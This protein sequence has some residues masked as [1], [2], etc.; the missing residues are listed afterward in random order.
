MKVGVLVPYTNTNLEKDLFSLT[1]PNVSFH[2]TRIGGYDLEEIPDHD[3][4]KKMGDSDLNESLNLISAI[5]P[6]IILYGCTSATLTRGLKYNYYL[7]NLIST[8]TNSK[9]VTAS[10]ALINAINDLKIK[11]IGFASPYE[12]KI[13]DN[14]ISFFSDAG[15][16]TISCSN[17][18]SKIK[19]LEQG[20]LK[21]SE[22]IELVLQA[23]SNNADAII[24][25][26]TDLKTLEIIEQLEKKLNK[27]VISSNQAMIYSLIKI[28]NIRPHNNFPGKL[29]KLFN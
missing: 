28:L 29:F 2:F 23:N 22:I 8:K 24:L 12:K 11:K 19:S 21:S 25:S 17:I 5:K 14:A 4:M 20:L 18:S 3:Q 27:P 6:D 15:I 9:V 16:K 13:N 10:S 26:C 7:E 1:L